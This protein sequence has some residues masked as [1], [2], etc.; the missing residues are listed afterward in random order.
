MNLSKKTYNRIDPEGKTLRFSLNRS[1]KNLW[2]LQSEIEIY[3]QFAEE[4]VGM[5]SK[6]SARKLGHS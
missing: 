3:G 1:F 5:G 6:V 4:E 2:P